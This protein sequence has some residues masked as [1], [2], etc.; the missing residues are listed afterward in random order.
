MNSVKKMVAEEQVKVEEES[1]ESF[2]LGERTEFVPRDLQWKTWSWGRI[3]KGDCVCRDAS[4]TLYSDGLADFSA[5]TST[6][7]SGDVWLFKGLAL[8][9]PYGDELYRIGQFN[10][11]RMELENYDYFVIRDRQSRP[12]FFPQQ[13]WSVIQGVNMIYHC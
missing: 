7:S 11:P 4:L 8:L 5:W 12:L 1:I 6:S 2:A 10:G 3:T 9:G 13:L